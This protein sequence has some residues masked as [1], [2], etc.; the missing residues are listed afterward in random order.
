M[1]RESALMCLV[2]FMIFQLD[3]GIVPTMLISENVGR[4]K[5]L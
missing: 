2:S 5:K 3:L 1:D 4:L